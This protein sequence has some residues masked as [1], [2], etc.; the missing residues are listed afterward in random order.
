MHTQQDF[1]TEWRVHLFIS[2]IVIRMT[3]PTALTTDQQQQMEAH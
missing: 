1:I 3:D 2:G